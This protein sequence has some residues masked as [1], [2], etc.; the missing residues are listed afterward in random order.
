MN[1]EI[2]CVYFY[3]QMIKLQRGLLSDSGFNRVGYSIG[4]SHV[5][6]Y[7]NCMD[8]LLKYSSS[9]LTLRVSE[10]LDWD[11]AQNLHF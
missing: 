10:S 11:E 5:R 4:A 7:P 1:N 8:S 6:I 2:S 9:G 3:M